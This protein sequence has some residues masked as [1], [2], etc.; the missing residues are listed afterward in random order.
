[1][2]KK[3]ILVAGLVA[4]LMASSAWAGNAYGCLQTEGD[5]LVNKCNDS[6]EV[7]WCEGDECNLTRSASWTLFV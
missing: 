2:L 5:Y 7:A 3:I 6:I 4:G 1:M